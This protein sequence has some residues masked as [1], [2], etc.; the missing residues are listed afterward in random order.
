M[1]LSK[2][3][4][5]LRTTICQPQMKKKDKQTTSE[6]QI[7]KKARHGSGGYNKEL[8]TRVHRMI[9]EKPANALRTTMDFLSCKWDE[10]GEVIMPMELYDENKIGLAKLKEDVEIAHK[11]MADN[12]HVCKADG[13]NDLG[14]MYRESDYPSEKEFRE[15]FFV[16]I[17]VLPVPIRVSSNHLHALLEQ[18][19]E[20]DKK[21]FRKML[22]EA[23]ADNLKCVT[24]QC[25]QRVY[26]ATEHIIDGIDHK[27]R[28]RGS[29][30][31]RNATYHDSLVGHVWDLVQ[32]LPKLNIGKSPEIDALHDALKSQIL[33]K[34]RLD[35]VA[36]T[37]KEK[38][39]KTEVAAMRE[40]V[41][42][43]NEVKQTASDI[44]K[45]AAAILPQTDN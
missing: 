18:D 6:I 25:A 19:K 15:R 30:A 41:T 35:D 29:N 33:G 8:Y 10:R 5:C 44:R 17:E 12:F 40:N 13:R 4:L 16:E 14:E 45:M 11:W 43:E 2:L 37:D 1:S 20:M 27:Q 24:E 32:I 28:P 7:L 34:L 39:L 23:E 22:D 21:A 42:L 38:R 26:K 36:K 3:A 31:K 9:I